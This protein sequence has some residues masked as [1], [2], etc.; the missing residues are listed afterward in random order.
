MKLF[1]KIVLAIF[2]ICLWGILASLCFG[3]TKLLPYFGV[4][5]I[6]VIIVIFSAAIIDQIF[7]G[8]EQKTPS[9]NSKGAE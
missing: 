9:E 3:W 5:M 2:L 7:A 8:W 1:I 6:G 4:P